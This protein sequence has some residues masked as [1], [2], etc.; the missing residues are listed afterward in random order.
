MTTIKDI[1]ALANVSPSTVSRI[2]NYDN[3]L[4]VK[5]ETK[6]KVLATADKLGYTKHKHKIKRHLT[7]VLIVQ[8]YPM[9]L[10]I[11]DPFYLSIRIGAEN[12][13]S[14]NNVEIIRYF[15]GQNDLNEKIK[16]IDGIICIGKFSKNEIT[17]FRK[18][19]DKLIFVDMF[20][21]RII[22]SYICL[23]MYHA[24][25]DAINYLYK[26]KHRKIGFIGG[27]EKLSDG[28]TYYELRK[29]YFIK[30]CKAHHIEYQKYISLGEFTIESGYL[31]AKQMIKNNN[32]PT[33]I[34]VASDQL[35]FGVLRAFSEH[36]IKVPEDISIVSFNND[37]N[38]SFTNPPLTTINAPSE[39]MGYLAATYL[40]THIKDKK[41]Y[42]TC[43]S[44][45]CELII[46]DSVKTL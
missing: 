20:L 19:T 35:A 5:D 2:L 7:R 42:P 45:P 15:K 4:K 12:Y 29:T 6:K 18:I 8:W 46:R 16:N 43:I 41:M 36:G 40:L 11:H 23:D 10:E 21:E 24:L 37:L 3:T 1:S 28:T 33:A 17:K 32:L 22:V 31:Q 25:E 44:L 38:S 34:F 13:L 39:P 27:I 30:F 26:Q 14:R 9:D